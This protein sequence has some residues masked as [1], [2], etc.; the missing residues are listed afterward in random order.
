MATNNGQYKPIPIDP[1]D[2]AMATADTSP[3]DLAYEAICAV[4][5]LMRDNYA[6]TKSRLMTKLSPVII[7]QFSITGGIYTLIHDGVHETV[8]P[9]GKNFELCKS[10]SHIPLG[11]YSMIAPYLREAPPVG[12]QNGILNFKK[13][14]T[15]ARDHLTTASL[16]QETDQACRTIIDAS[17]AFLDGTIGTSGFSIA[18][19]TQYTS[20]IQ[21]AI[22]TNMQTA[23]KA[24]IEGVIPLLERWRKQLGPVK[25]KELYAVTMAIWT[26]EERNQ[27]WL[28]LK[29]MMDPATVDTHLITIAN[30]A[31]EENTV[32]IALENLARI[33]H[34]KIA[35]SM[36]FSAATQ[37]SY[38]HATALI[39]PV[40][41]LA[42]TIE[43][44]LK[45][46]PHRPSA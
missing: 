4:D 9:V 36:V 10:I 5:S 42:G 31:P 32:P 43:E 44:M 29:H 25:W 26:T 41:L 40:D 14:I 35:A 24:Q 46:C 7:V 22:H 19:F 27:N 21:D 37:F 30:A 23:V 11:I 1:H 12:W 39:G 17:V 45:G 3:R 8:S 13:V 20:Q 15:N 2:L 38:E 28:L 34:D 33:V 6:K 18:A 16:P